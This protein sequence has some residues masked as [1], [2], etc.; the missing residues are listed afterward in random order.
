MLL[1]V[2]KPGKRKSCTFRPLLVKAL[3]YNWWKSCLAK[4]SPTKITTVKA[5]LSPLHHHHYHSYPLR[6]KLII[7]ALRN[8]P[9]TFAG[10]RGVGASGVGG[11]NYSDV[12]VKDKYLDRAWENRRF[13][14][15]TSQKVTYI[16]YKA[17]DVFLIF[18]SK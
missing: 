2:Q 5:A 13:F 4:G 18:Y 14:F 17:M 7:F 12:G 10:G 1:S 11:G 16:H 3:S 15:L 9:S 6:P 8:L